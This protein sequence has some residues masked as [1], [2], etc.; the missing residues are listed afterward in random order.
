[1]T[2]VFPFPSEIVSHFA[3]SSSMFRL[4]DNICMLH[5]QVSSSEEEEEDE[6]IPLPR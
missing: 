1:M 5:L 6:E 4:Y 2:L 3:C